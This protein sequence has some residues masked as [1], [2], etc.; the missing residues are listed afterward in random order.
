MANKCRNDVQMKFS[1]KPRRARLD[2]VE[3]W[4]IEEEKSEGHSFNCNFSLIANSFEKKNFHCVTSGSNTLGFCVFETFSNYG[5][6]NIAVVDFNQRG[7]GI[8]E[9]L[10]ASHC[11]YI[12]SRGIKAVEVECMPL[13]SAHFWEHIGFVPIPEGVDPNYYSQPRAT[14]WKAIVDVCDMSSEEGSDGIIELWNAEPWKAN[15]IQPTWSW[16]LNLEEIRSKPIVFPANRNWR[17]RWRKAGDVIFDEKYKY[18][19][20]QTKNQTKYLV[21][22]SKPVCNV[23]PGI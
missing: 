17:L 16:P 8:G 14:K 13:S 23:D 19:S 6:V 2:Q 4:L 12:S 7:K 22:D 5:V 20:E 15:D 21:I 10:I 3:K 11:R 18:F 1:V 9:Y